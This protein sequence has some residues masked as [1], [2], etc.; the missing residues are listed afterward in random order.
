MPKQVRDK[1][2]YSRLIF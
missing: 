1:T 2:R